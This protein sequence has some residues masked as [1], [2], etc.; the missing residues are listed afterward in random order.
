VVAPELSFV[1]VKFVDVILAA[2][3]KLSLGGGDACT[4]NVG[5]TTGGV[6]LGL[7]TVVPPPG[8]GFWTP[9]ELVLP[10]LA[11]KV[12]GTVAVS[13]VALTKVVASGVPPTS[14][15]IST[16]EADVKP[17]PFTVIVVAG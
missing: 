5:N 8:G 2:L 1:S 13:W 15:F 11:R 6:A 3:A 10:K 4:I 9:T 16:L 17:V 7:V 14:G 12:A